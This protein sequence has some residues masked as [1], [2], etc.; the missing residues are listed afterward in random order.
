MRNVPEKES[1]I[2]KQNTFRVPQRF[3]EI[4]AVYEII[5]KKYS[6][7]RQDTD[8]AILLRRNDAIDMPRNCGKDTVTLK[9]FNTYCFSAAKMT[10]RKQHS[11]TLYLHCLSLTF[12]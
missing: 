7:A 6:R 1:C 2:E 5:G 4:R 3:H 10:T 11:V 8:G 12:M 9:I